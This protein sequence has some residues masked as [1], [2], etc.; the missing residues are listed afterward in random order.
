[1]AAV[2]RDVEQN[3]DCGAGESCKQASNQQTNEQQNLSAGWL[4]AAGLGRCA[5]FYATI[6]TL[7]LVGAIIVTTLNICDF[8][9]VS[10]YANWHEVK[11]LQI[12]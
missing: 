10:V 8:F 2:V 9:T 11:Y 12:R 3:C 1:L 6:P 5:A 7:P 4:L